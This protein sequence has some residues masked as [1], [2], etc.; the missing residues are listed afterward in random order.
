MDSHMILCNVVL[1]EGP[2]S[3]WEMGDL[4]SEPAVLIK[5]ATFGI[6]PNLV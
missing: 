5:G 3:P 1:D 4:A 2:G 6:I